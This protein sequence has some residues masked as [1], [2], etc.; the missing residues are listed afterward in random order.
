MD[1]RTVVVW[2]RWFADWRRATEMGD[3]GDGGAL[4]QEEEDAEEAH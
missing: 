4:K 1:E 3:D 2:W